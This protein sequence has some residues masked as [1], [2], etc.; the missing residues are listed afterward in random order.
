MKPA[1][2]GKSERAG[3]DIEFTRKSG[4][5]RVGGWYDSMVGIEG[6]E[7]PLREFLDRIGISEKDCKRAFSKPAGAGT[8]G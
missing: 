2:F 8:E 7:M 3:I 4:I 1:Y 5:V 6:E